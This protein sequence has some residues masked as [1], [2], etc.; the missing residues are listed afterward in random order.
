MSLDRRILIAD[1][2]PQIRL[3]TAELL[4]ALGLDIVMA[5]TGDDALRI[6]RGGGLDLALLDY[7]MPGA[8]GLEII[9]AMTSELLGIP[10][11]LCSADAAGDVGTLAR[12]A[13][14]FAVLCKPILPAHLRREVVRALELPPSM[15]LS[16]LA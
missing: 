3:G 12:Q 14:A 2:D 13:G 5:E 11:I 15:G 6:I 7:H 9:Q 10:A 8:N 4:G 16:G 1:D